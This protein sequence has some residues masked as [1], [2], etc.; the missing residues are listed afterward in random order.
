M[1][2]WLVAGIS[3]LL[4]A[5]LCKK[6]NAV[7]QM[8]HGSDGNH[9]EQFVPCMEGVVY[10]SSFTCKKERIRRMSRCIKVPLTM[11]H[12]KFWLYTG[13]CKTSS[14]EYSVARISEKGLAH[15]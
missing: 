3:H 6:V 5:S 15:R 9:R 14:R 12:Q 1:A 2:G 8:P 11:S 10:F 7:T 13:S 4:Y